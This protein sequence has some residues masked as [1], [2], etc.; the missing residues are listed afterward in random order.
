MRSIS[1]Q[2]RTFLASMPTIVPGDV[3]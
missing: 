1:K 2:T 3:R